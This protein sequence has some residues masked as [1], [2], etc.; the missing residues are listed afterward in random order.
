MTITLC[1]DTYELIKNSFVFAER[2]EFEIKGFGTKKLY[3]LLGEQH[4]G[5]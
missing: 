3:T 5:D 1:D 4:A 2:G